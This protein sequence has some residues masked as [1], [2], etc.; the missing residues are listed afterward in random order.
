MKDHICVRLKQAYEKTM[1]KRI[2]GRIVASCELNCKKNQKN[3]KCI[4]FIKIVNK[5]ISKKFNMEI[6]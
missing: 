1:N 2:T 6:I 4:N 5:E 3:K